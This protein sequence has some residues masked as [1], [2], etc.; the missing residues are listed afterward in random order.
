MESLAKISSALKRQNVL[1]VV[2]S[3]NLTSLLSF[4]FVYIIDLQNFVDS[5][6]YRREKLIDQNF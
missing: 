4:S 6:F 5:S 3:V 2:R 1:K